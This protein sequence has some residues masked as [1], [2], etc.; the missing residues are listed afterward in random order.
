MWILLPLS[1]LSAS[2]VLLTEASTWH[3]RIAALLSRF[4]ISMGLAI[5]F[6]SPA[7]HRSRRIAEDIS[8]LCSYSFS[9]FPTLRSSGFLQ[10]HCSLAAFD[11]ACDLAARPM[12]QLVWNPYLDTISP[13]KL[14]L[15]CPYYSAWF[16][17]DNPETFFS[18][19]RLTTLYHQV[20]SSSF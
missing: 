6:P 1:P 9:F 14:G 4:H 17:T 5:R 10:S 3:Q 12:E 18:M 15:N 20:Q 7:D 13:V 8:L 2:L 16:V 19:S 11:C